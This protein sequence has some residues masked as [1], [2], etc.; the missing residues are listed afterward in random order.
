MINAESAIFEDGV[1]YS[2]SGILSKAS[3]YVIFAHESTKSLIK[4]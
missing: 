3:F 1:M 4:A 2:V